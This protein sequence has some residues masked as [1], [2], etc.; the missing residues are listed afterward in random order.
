MPYRRNVHY[1]LY[2]WS[3]FIMA[4]QAL[5]SSIG[6][7]TPGCV[8]CYILSARL[9]IQPQIVPLREHTVSQLLNVSKVPVL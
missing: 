8:Q 9:F 4:N 3:S 1:G 7:L 6:M 2:H 5:I